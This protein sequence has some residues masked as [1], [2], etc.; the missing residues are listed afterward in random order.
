[1]HEYSAKVNWERQG[2]TFIDGRYSRRHVLRF[3]GGAEVPASASPL[4]VRAPYSDPAGV[5]PEELFIASLASC[6]M[7]WFLSLAAGEGFTVERYTDDAVG[8][9]EPAASGKLHMAVV[10]LRPAA[11]FAGDRRPTP[12]DIARLHRMAHEACFIANSVR[13]EVRCE[14]SA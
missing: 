14:P 4:V 5:D 6:H 7:L 8:R 9:L 1:M 11:R 13:T 12:A 10:T 3:D 2:D